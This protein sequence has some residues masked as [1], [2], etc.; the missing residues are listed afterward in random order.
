[1]DATGQSPLELLF[2]AEN[3]MTPEQRRSMAS[4]LIGMLCGSV[5]STTWARMVQASAEFARRPQ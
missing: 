5:D 3:G 2:D 4:Y 1:M